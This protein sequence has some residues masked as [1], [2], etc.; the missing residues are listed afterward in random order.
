MRALDALERGYF[1]KELPHSFSSK[2]FAHAVP[3]LTVD[4]PKTWTRPVTLNLARPGTLRR[5]LAIPNPFSQA[6]LVFTCTSNWTVLDSHL[7]QSKIS[8]SRPVARPRGR[9]LGFRIP[10]RGRPAE[11]V[12]RMGRARYTLRSDISEFYGSIYTHSLEWAIH[13]KQLAKANLKAH[14]A[15]LLG[16]LLDKQVRL[17]QDGQTKG[18]PIG[19][20]TSFLMA[21]IILCAV[22]VELQNKHPQTADFCFRL[23]DDLEF[24]AQSRGEA[25]DVLLA[26]DSLLKGYELALNP[27]K[28]EII[29]GPI[30]PEASRRVHLSQFNF[31]TETDTVLANDIYSFFSLA[32]ELAK[33]NKGEPILSYAVNRVNPRPTEAKSWKAFSELL[34]AAIVAD[35]SS[36]GNVS[37][38]LEWAI[39]EDLPMNRA[40]L[41]D[42]LNAMCSYHAPLEHGSEVSWSLS[43]MRDLD[44][45]LHSEAAGRVAQMQDNCSLLLLFDCIARKK[46]TDAAPNMTDVVARAEDPEAWKSEDWLL[47]YECGR[48]G[49]ASDKYFQA[50]DHWKEIRQLGVSFFRATPSTPVP[51]VSSTAVSTQAAPPSEP[52]AEAAAAAEAAVSEEAEAEAEAAAEAAYEDA[53]AAAAAEEDETYE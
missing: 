30:P 1:P 12:A 31:R 39:S 14:G 4:A 51:A 41:S 44:L 13:T 48:N 49:W 6:A 7:S 21:E 37:A 9:A 28:T 32:F 15:A 50:Q 11:R 43:I 19:P 18:I 5:P 34:L 40:A 26:W 47:G 29:D 10:F 36:L 22:D 20:D 25:E 23:M 2:S 17:G 3:L 46:I 42:T 53:A 24:S 38:A 33:Q 16:G 52:E 35:P 8:I 45:P 27:M